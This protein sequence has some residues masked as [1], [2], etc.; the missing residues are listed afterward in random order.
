MYILILV[1]N[2]Y[3][4]MCQQ[5]CTYR[6]ANSPGYKTNLPGLPYG[7]PNLLH[8]SKFGYFFLQKAKNQVNFISK[9]KKI[10]HFL[11]KDGCIVVKFY[12]I[13]VYVNPF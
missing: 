12:S 2:I 5:Y 7:S 11:V 13:L 4:S 8:K 10:L 1:K 3:Y 9:L 6:Y